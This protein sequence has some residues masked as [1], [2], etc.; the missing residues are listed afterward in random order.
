MGLS[1]FPSTG[2]PV[3]LFLRELFVRALCSRGTVNA[4]A[5]YE[6]IHVRMP[7]RELAFLFFVLLE[8]PAL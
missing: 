3:L 8:R 4:S 1:F 7:V 2:G 6:L 5:S